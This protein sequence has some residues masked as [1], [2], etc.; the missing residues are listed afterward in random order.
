MHAERDIVMASPSVCLS[1]VD[2]V[3]K[4][5]DII[6]TLLDDLV[7]KGTAPPSQNSKTNLLSRALN[8]R[9]G[10]FC[11]YLFVISE[12]VRDKPIVTMEQ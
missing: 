5:M 4:R 10:Q 11:I 3:S 6:V 7:S 2:I 1:N 8:K 9:G 12:T